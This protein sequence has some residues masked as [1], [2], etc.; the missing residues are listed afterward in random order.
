L[1]SNKKEVFV[2]IKPNPILLRHG[3]DGYRPQRWWAIMILTASMCAATGCV[4]LPTYDSKTDDLLTN[5]QKDTDTFIAVLSNTYDATT[6]SG[7]ACAYAANTKSYQGFKIDIG[8]LRTRASALYDNQVTVAALDKLQGTYDAL[9]AA[10]KEADTRADHCILPALLVVDQQAM[11]SAIGA[12]L[13][14]ELAKKGS[15]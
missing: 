4:P 12:L 8:L 15:S 13:K 14:L 11:D 9:E 6:T 7:K 3:A 1:I 10:H 2:N 5:L